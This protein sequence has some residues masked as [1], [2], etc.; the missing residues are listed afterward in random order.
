LYVTHNIQE[1][2]YL[3]DRVIVLSRRPGRIS[4]I[5]KID[6]PK[7]GRDDSKYITQFNNYAEEIWQMIRKDAQEALQE[8][9]Q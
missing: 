7:F 5:I 8:G 3:A 9:D 1:A 4:S 6:L 2:V